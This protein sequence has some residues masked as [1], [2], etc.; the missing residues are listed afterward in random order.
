ML[1]QAA[2]FAP[3]YRDSGWEEDAASPVRRALDLILRYQDPIPA[4]G[5]TPLWDIVQMNGAA[6]RVFAH[7]IRADATGGWL[8]TAANRAEVH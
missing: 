5:V 8:R 2:G 4:V 1:L 7:F 3:V 6:L